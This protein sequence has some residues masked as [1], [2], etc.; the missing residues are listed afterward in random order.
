[1]ESFNSKVRREGQAQIPKFSAYAMDWNPG[2][3]YYSAKKKNLLPLAVI[4]VRKPKPT[5]K[6]DP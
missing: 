2:T 1:M 3:F 5:K 4:E 6:F